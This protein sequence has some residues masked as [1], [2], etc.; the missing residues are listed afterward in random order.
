MKTEKIITDVKNFAMVK[1]KSKNEDTAL[2]RIFLP[3]REMMSCDQNR[4]QLH[5]TKKA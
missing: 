3:E 4:F 5:L 2:N 1:A